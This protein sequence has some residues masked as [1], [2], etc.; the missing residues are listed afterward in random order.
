MLGNYSAFFSRVS[1]QKSLNAHDNISAEIEFEPKED[2]MEANVEV[3]MYLETVIKEGLYSTKGRLQF[4][5]ETL[6]CGVDLKNKSILDIGGGFGL[7][8]FY[9]ACKG[10]KKVVCLE[11]ESDGSSFGVIG[12]FNRLNELLCKNNVTLEPKALQNIGASLGS[13][14]IVLIHNSVNH[15]D[16]NACISLLTNSQSREIYREIFSKIFKLSNNGAK[17]I[18][19]DCSRNNFFDLLKVRNPFL[20][21]I[22]WHK[23]Q[24]PEVWAELLC[25]VG[26]KN[27]RI[28]WSSFNALRGLGKIIFGNRIMSYFLTSH[29]RMIMDKP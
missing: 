29:F 7:Y 5:M 8:S 13:F 24:Q 14:D 27:P 18:L 6:F 10:A 25:E 3:D 9:A 11:P 23:H 12:K 15:L 20:P 22:E 28:T 21:A 17:L 4:E 1:E 19:C 2:T 26:F 16:E